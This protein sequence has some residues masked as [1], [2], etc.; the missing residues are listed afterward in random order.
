MQILNVIRNA[1][2]FVKEHQGA[3]GPA[4]PDV[5]WHESASGGCMTILPS[6]WMFAW[7]VRLAESFPSFME[8]EF[9]HDIASV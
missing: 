2:Q 1:V 6:Y 8:I 3:L 7:P 4:G 9:T 5:G